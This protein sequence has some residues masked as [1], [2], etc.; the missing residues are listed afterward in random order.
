MDNLNKMKVSPRYSNK[1]E[2]H[3]ASIAIPSIAVSSRP[4]ISV[5]IHQI[6]RLSVSLPLFSLSCL[7]L[8]N[9]EAYV[10]HHG[11][12]CSESTSVHRG[13]NDTLSCCRFSLLFL[14]RENILH[15]IVDA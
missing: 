7:H 5:W 3:T 8:A 1:C 4:F 15:F 13:L 14:K 10:L 2:Y 9:D 12:A 6:Y 11:Y